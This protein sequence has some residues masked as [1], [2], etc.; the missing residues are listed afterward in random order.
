MDMGEEKRFEI[1]YWVTDTKAC[2]RDTDLLPR[3]GVTLVADSL[4]ESLERGLGGLE[5]PVGVVVRTNVG[6]IVPRDDLDLGE[7]GRKIL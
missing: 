4:G 3:S 5:N 7:L 6:A 2:I 1:R